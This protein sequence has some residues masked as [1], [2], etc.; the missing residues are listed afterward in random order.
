MS[1]R[2]Q[3]FFHTLKHLNIANVKQPHRQSRDSTLTNHEELLNNESPSLSHKTQSF[4]GCRLPLLLPATAVITMIIPFL[5]LLQTC[6][7]IMYIK[8]LR[9]SFTRL[10]CLYVNEKSLLFLITKFK[11]IIYQPRSQNLMLKSRLHE[12]SIPMTFQ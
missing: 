2:Q 4:D 9:F 3:T 12:K 5:L 11:L 8:V 7:G 10:K 6:I 1:T